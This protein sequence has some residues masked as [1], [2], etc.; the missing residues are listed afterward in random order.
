VTKVLQFSSGA[1]ESP[2]KTVMIPHPPPEEEEEEGEGEEEEELV[3][4]SICFS[5]SSRTCV[6][7]CISDMS[8]RMFC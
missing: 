5:R 8:L 1:K 7:R 6:T 3:R 2:N 4:F